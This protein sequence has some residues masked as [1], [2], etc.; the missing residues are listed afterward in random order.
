MK[1][2]CMDCQNES[3]SDLESLKA[4]KH[5]ICAQCTE[6]VRSHSDKEV[7]ASVPLALNEHFESHSDPLNEFSPK[8]EIPA[9]DE[10]VLE[11]SDALIISD[12]A[13]QATDDNVIL[14]PEIE[15]QTPLSWEEIYLGEVDNS[16][17]SA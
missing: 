16:L 12:H 10:E 8:S 6:K 13:S 3:Y 14:F 1:I 4:N 15:T 5:F 17:E 7:G 9:Q 2:V 11:L